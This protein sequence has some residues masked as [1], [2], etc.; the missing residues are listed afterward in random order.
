[1]KEENWVEMSCEEYAEKS[2]AQA[3]RLADR[4][5]LKS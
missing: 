3:N 4:M 1:M 2:V 5:V